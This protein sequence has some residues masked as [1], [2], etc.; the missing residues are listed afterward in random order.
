ML[1]KTVQEINIGETASFTKTVTE[2]DVYSI[3][4]VTGDFNPA[5]IDSEFASETSFL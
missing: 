5:H 1:G 2:Y 4:G 3:A